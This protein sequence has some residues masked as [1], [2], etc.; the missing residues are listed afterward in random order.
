MTAIVSPSTGSTV[1]DKIVADKAAQLQLLKSE[2]PEAEI[3]RGLE[4]SRRS[5]FNA[6]NQP[7]AGFIL[8][9]KKASP[10]KGL[11]RDDFNLEE[12]VGTYKK[13]AAAISVLT[14]EKYFQGRFEYVRE[15]RALA[16]QPIINKDF[17]VDPYQIYLA[18]Y[19]GADAI[20]LMLSVLDDD[21]YRALADVAAG[22][23]MDI[24]TEVS[25]DE[26]LERALALDA[27]ILGIN[28]RDLRDLSTD[29][30]T[31]K[32]L[33][34]AK[35]AER[36]I[37]SES[38][39][40]THAQVRELAQ[41]A[42]AFLVG[43]SLMAQADVDIA[44]RGLIFGETKV[45]GLTREEDVR[46]VAAAGAS[47][48]GLIF[49]AK[50]PR[51]VD[52]PTA[53]SLVAVAKL[54]FV[55]VFVNQP[56]EQVAQYAH[57]LK[58]A[59]VQ[60][61]G[62]ESDDYISRLATHLPTGCRIWQA[63]R[64]DKLPNVK[65]PRVDRLLIDSVKGQQFGGTGETFDWHSVPQS[66]R[67]SAML[68]GGLSPDNIALALDLGFAGVDVN[69]G[70]ESAPGIKDADKLNTLMAIVRRY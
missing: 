8:E 53:Q 40:Y 1:L 31:T 60:L 4:P 55:G 43:S 11:I 35:S 37:V 15:V 18:R 7:D 19:M 49:A 33:A 17:F 34:P 9:C 52:L 48:G 3:R 62:G 67:E 56:L 51:C 27:K 24:L 64:A 69:S 63:V 47:Y 12:I 6:L 44:C 5:L 58:L 59:V 26:E 66:L 50:S 61:H 21:Q 14:D 65:H 29:L 68:A 54:Q 38:G 16:D 32:R 23:E 42:N 36:V 25:N 39:I 2:Y 20:L 57:R 10:S 46:R 13:Y 22:L 41:Y 28:N 45:C 30:A 70:I